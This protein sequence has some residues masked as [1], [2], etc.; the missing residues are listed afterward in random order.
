MTDKE[1]VKKY[2]ELKELCERIAF[3]KSPEELNDLSWQEKFV[4][5]FQMI[6]K[7]AEN[8]YKQNY[9]KLKEAVDNIKE[10]LKNCQKIH[11]QQGTS[12]SEAMASVYNTCIDVI[13]KHTEG[14]I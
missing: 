6:T 5:L 3:A 14:L 12:E 9:D 13:D 2:D 8:N 10:S 4:G 7:P 1:K 11:A